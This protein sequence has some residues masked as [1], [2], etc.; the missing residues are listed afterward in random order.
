MSPRR[1][2][3][4]LQR[5][6][7]KGLASHSPE[8]PRRYLPARPELA[9]EA[10]IQQ[11]QAVLDRARSAIPLLKSLASSAFVK[12]EIDLVEVVTS[13]AALG[14]LLAQLQQTAQHEIFGFQRAPVL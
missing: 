1:A 13:R 10:L 14:Q 6:E 2:Q 3:A 8:R 9:I 11:Q 7:T 5:V 12:P 4:L